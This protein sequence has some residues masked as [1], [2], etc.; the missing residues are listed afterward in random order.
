MGGANTAIVTTPG[1]I[2]KIVVL[3]AW[4]MWWK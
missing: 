3:K 2:L 4:N 1:Y